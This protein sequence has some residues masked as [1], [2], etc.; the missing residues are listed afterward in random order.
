[1]DV[2][3]VEM[4][5]WWF[6]K[7]SGESKLGRGLGCRPVEEML[8]WRPGR[9]RGKTSRFIFEK[10]TKENMRDN[11]K[12][13]RKKIVC[14]DLNRKVFVMIR[15]VEREAKLRSQIHAFC[16]LCAPGFVGS[17]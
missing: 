2:G 11:C 4:S 14:I 1:M 17:Q 6:R 5:R 7:E 13:S 10:K 9:T 16:L 15:T 8:G 12:L 3:S